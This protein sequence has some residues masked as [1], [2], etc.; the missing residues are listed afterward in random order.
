[1]SNI[2]KLSKAY[3]FSTTPVC[4]FILLGSSTWLVHLLLN[5]HFSSIGATKWGREGDSD[6]VGSFSAPSS[7]RLVEKLTCAC[8][9]QP[10]TQLTPTTAA[11]ACPAHTRDQCTHMRERAFALRLCSSK[12][13]GWFASY[14]NLQNSQEKDHFSISTN[15]ELL[16]CTRKTI[17]IFYVTYTSIINK[18]KF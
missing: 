12:F 15:M 11:H 6:I 3:A 8:S 9:W 1:M 7:P 13:P 2:K 14:S 4:L 18:W 17:I 10:L 5:L 16:W